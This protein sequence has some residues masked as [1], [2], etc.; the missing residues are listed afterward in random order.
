VIRVR[1]LEPAA[2]AAWN[3]YVLSRPGTHFAQRT[4]WLHLETEFFPVAARWLLASDESDRIVGI[5]PAFRGRTTLFSAPGGIV[6]DSPEAAAALIAQAREEVGRDRLRWLELRDQV[7]RWPGLA[8]N[9]EHVT[10]VLDLAASE[11]ALWTS[12]P[13][14][15]RNQIRKAERSG[16]DCRRG[17]DQLAAFH[18]VFSENMRDLGTPAMEPAYF[19]RALELYGGDAEVLVVR[20]GDLAVGGMLVVR[21][22]DTLFDPWASSLRRFFELC[23]NNLLYWDAQRHALAVGARRFDF[24]RSQPG[25]GT[26]RFKQQFGAR[27]VALHYQYALGRAPRMPTLGEQKSSLGLAVRIWRRLPLP[28]TRALGPRARRFFPEAL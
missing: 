24:G 16:L 17:H 18:R 23:P 20:R 12:F 4:E 28:V 2:E 9:P 1:R 21:H 22:G 5:L 6:A 8:T 15:V 26:F 27:S 14:K 11:E 25:S 13:A 7:A 10:L 3:E 19:R